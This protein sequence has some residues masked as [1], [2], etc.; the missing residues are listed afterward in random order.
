MTDGADSLRHRDAVLDVS[1]RRALARL[2][3]PAVVAT[4]AQATFVIVDAIYVGRWLGTDPMAAVATSAFVLWSLGALTGSVSVGVSAMLARRVGEGR[5]EGAA[6]V[7]RQGVLLAVVGSL[8]VALIGW[9]L[10]PWAF[11]LMDVD[12]GV[13]VLGT[14]YLRVLFAGSA[15]L[16]LFQVVEAVFRALGDTKTPLKLLLASVAA[17]LLLDPLLILG[18]GPFPD[19]GVRGAAWA[20]VLA[21]GACALVA[22]AL[23]VRRGVLTSPSLG[24]WRPHFRTWLSV[25]RIGV[26]ASANGVFFCAVY[27]ILARITADFGTPALA[28]LGVGHKG[29]A[30]CYFV[31]LGISLA[32]APLVGQSL[33]AGLP[34]RAEAAAW[35]AVRTACAWGVVWTVVLFTIP[36]L[37]AGAFVEERAV[38]HMATRYLVIMGFSQVLMCVEVVLDGAFAGAGDTLPP[39]LIGM[40][41]TAARIPLA[42]LLA[43]P[44]GLGAD[45]IWIA[46]T[47]S[48]LAKGTL[49]AIWFRRGRWKDRRIE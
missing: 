9:P 43:H 20:S 8:L 27:M 22:V 15:S 14:G 41:L 47:V 35:L 33:G 6:S 31:A 42:W 37:V 23:M 1:L 7:V 49:M 30:P 48:T 28:A 21:R 2:A 29:E 11:E 39:L 44:A 5:A 19:L 26:P 40:P 38:V 16:F 25:L 4:V 32:V 24:A 13:A 17:N 18:L 45:G 34:A 10:A 3:W 12:V 46:V 36:E